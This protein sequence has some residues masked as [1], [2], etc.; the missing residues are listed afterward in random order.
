MEWQGLLIK[1]TGLHRPERMVLFDPLALPQPQGRA[2]FPG[3]AL[4]SHPQGELPLAQRATRQP[5][6]QQLLSGR[7][8]SALAS[9]P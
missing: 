8:C 6:T 2:R 5:F 4:A 3:S 1:P 9:H 7:D